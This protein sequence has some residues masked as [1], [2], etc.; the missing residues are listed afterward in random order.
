M[1]LATCIQASG[2][3][4][5][6][7]VPAKSSDVLEWLRTKTKQPGLQFQGKIQ[8]KDNWITIF[9]ESGSDDDDTVNQHVLGGNFAD[10]IFVGSMVVMLSANSNADNYD[11]PS[12]SYQNLKPA[13]YETIYSS[14]TFEGESS[15]DEDDADADADADDDEG[16]NEDDAVPPVD[17]NEEDDDDDDD[18]VGEEDAPAPTTKQ[19]KPKQ[20]VIHDVNT[21]CPLRDRVKQNYTEIGLTLELSETLENALLQR[22][23]RDCAKQE[24]EVTWNNP[25]FWNHYRGRCMQFYEN[26]RN[27]GWVP[28]LLSGEVA[29]ATFAE[30]TVVDLNPKRWKAQIEAQIEK[31]KKLFTRSGNASIF[32][33]CSRCKKTTKCDYYQMQTRSADEPMTTFVSCLECDRRWK[34]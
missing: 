13:E 8:D 29:P 18:A 30:M 34:F 12:S 20:V 28:K 5:E 32:F 19:R 33:F 3:L 25:A 17:E 31:D 14:W 7:T 24:I 21:P 16:V 23:I 2:T 10:E 22:C 11:K 4:Q 1:V 26:M 15:A 6:L 9:A 27:Y